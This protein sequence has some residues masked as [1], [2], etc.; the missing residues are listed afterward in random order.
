MFPEMTDSININ[1]IRLDTH[2]IDID[3][4]CRTKSDTTNGATDQGLHNY[5]LFH[6]SVGTGFRQYMRLHGQ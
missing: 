6:L 1:P 3:K 5:L 4:Q 2:E